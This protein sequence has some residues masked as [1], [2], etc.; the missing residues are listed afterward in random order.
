MLMGRAPFGGQ[1]PS[2]IFR[3]TCHGRLGL[4]R[5][6]AAAWDRLPET[7]KTL[8]VGL[9][10]LDH[11]LRM[12]GKQAVEHPWLAGHLT[13][14]SSSGGGGKASFSEP[15]NT[16]NLEQEEKSFEGDSSTGGGSTAVLSCGTLSTC[17]SA[18]T[19]NGKATHA[20]P[21]AGRLDA[22]AR[23]HGEE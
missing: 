16:G 7:A 15:T 1:T 20:P 8:I 12:T 13:A 23:A 19:L 21:T 4:G 3:N 9:M 14:A 6:G 18:S 10:Q 11:N 17:S 22:R 5:G 2:E